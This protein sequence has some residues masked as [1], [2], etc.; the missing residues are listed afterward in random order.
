MCGLCGVLAAE[1]HWTERTGREEVFG[2]QAA[3]RPRRQERLKRVALANKILAHYGL[4]LG[5]WDG[6]QLVLSSFTGRSE[7]VRHVG[8]LWPAAERVANR[9]CDPLDPALIAAIERE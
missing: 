7:V 4:K 5:D 1:A 9:P 2:A 6:S 3:N 8:A